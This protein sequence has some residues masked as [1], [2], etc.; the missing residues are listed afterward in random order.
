MI[1]FSPSR[2]DALSSSFC[3]AKVAVVGDLMLDRYMF[4]QV[5][6]I[7]PEAPVPVLDI[8]DEQARLGGAANVGHN[9]HGLGATPLMLGVIGD[10]TSGLLLKGLFADLGFPLDGIITDQTRPTTVK[11]RVIAGSQQML[12][13]DHENKHDI[14]KETEDRLIGAIEDNI[15]QLDAIILED[16]NKGVVTRSVIKRVIEVGNKH[17]KP[18]LVDPKFQNF[19]EYKECTVF[20]PNRK[21]TEDALNVRM[22]SET[23]IDHAGKKLLE[24]LNAK[25]VLLTMGEKGMMLFEK[26]EATPFSIP[27]RARK[28]ADVSG[29][30]DT[31][32]ATLAVAMSCG[33]SLREAAVLA[34]RAAGL[35]VE[36][37]GII[38]IYRERL[39]EALIEDEASAHALDQ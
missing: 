35:V 31:V 37:L 22:N 6:R 26:G 12:R 9:I 20:K 16:Y 5:S 34:N 17:G 4:G 3:A 25:N 10:D 24:V 11:T 32:I 27:T 18:V 21:E 28:V 7:S 15:G 14:S 19:F 36:E 23:E 2:L 30:G 33:I 39:I 38:P 29:A 1:T 13:I 8:Q